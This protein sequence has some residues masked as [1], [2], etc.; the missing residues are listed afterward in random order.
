MEAKFIFHLK[1]VFEYDFVLGLGLFLSYTITG[2]FRGFLPGPAE[3]PHPRPQRV[4]L[5]RGAQ[6]SARGACVWAHMFR[7]ACGRAFRCSEEESIEQESKGACESGIHMSG[8]C[9]SLPNASLYFLCKSH[10]FR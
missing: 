6:L 3:S 2:A 10:A 7:L 8:R 5:A 1:F 9:N 4:P